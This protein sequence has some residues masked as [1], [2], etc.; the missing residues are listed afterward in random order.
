[1]ESLEG[2]LKIIED[3]RK[4]LSAEIVVQEESGHKE[5][6]YSHSPGH[7]SYDPFGPDE[8][9]ANVIDQPR[10]AEPDNEKRAK[11]RNELRRIHD[12]SSESGVVKYV[13]AKSLGIETNSGMGYYPLRIWSH[14]HPVKAT[15]TG[16]AVAGATSGLGYAL[17]EY[18][19]K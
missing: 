17:I 7:H 16:I 5:T 8:Y 9:E 13:A 2:A 11:V 18:F 1:M 15:I 10:I 3:L 14:E 19:S 4:D 6:K 12:S